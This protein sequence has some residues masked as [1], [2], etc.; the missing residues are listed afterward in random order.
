MCIKFG[1]VV[2]NT[3][4]P[5]THHLILGV[6]LTLPTP[7]PPLPRKQEV[8]GSGVRKSLESLPQWDSPSPFSSAPHGN[9]PTHAHKKETLWR[10]LVLTASSN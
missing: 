6:P 4:P 1:H 9:D 8:A 3:K 5:T 10:G 2:R 7:T